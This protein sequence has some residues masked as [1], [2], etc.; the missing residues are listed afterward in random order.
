[1]HIY[2]DDQK[3]LNIRINIVMGVIS[4]LFIVLMGSF[5]WVQVLHAEKYRN[6]SAANALRSAPVTAKRGLIMDR[7]GKILADNQPSYSLVLS[8]TDLK[9][10]VK[11]DSQYEQK[12]VRF[13]AATLAITPAEVEARI[14]KGKNIPVNQ[15]LPLS[16]DL[17]MPQVAQIQANRLQFS[18]LDIAPVQRRNYRYGTMAAHVIGYMG[19]AAEKDL[20][21]DRS[22][23]PGDFV[24]KKGVEFVYDNLLRG[25]DGARYMVVDSHGRP[26]EELGSARKDPVAGHNVYLTLD[27][28]LQRL[29]EKYFIDNEFV[30][31]AV[32][33]DPKS[34]EVLAMVSSPAFNPNVFSKRFTPDMWAT[35]TSNPFH[36][37]Q[38][39]AIQGLYSPGSVFKTVMA[40]AGLENGVITPSTDFE[41][42]GSAVFY[43]RRFH[44]WRK[45]GHGEISVEDALKMSC[46]IFFYNTGSRLGVDRIADYAHN[47]TFGKVS[48]IDLE[49]ELPGLVPSEEWAEKVQ[50]RKWYP[51]ETISVSIGQGPLVVTVLQVANMMAAIAN[52]GNVYQP[53]VLKAVEELSGDGRKSL[54]V[55]EPKVISSVHLPQSALVAVR[56]GL[57]KVVN[58]EGGTAGNA[59]VAGL[60]I[61]GKTGTVQVTNETGTVSTASMPFKFR[62]HAWFA[63]FAPRD[64]PQMVVVVFIEHAG[65]HGGTD[66]APLAKMLY[67]SRFRTLLANGNLNLSDPDVLEQLKEGQLPKPGQETKA[68]AIP[69]PD[70]R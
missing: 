12:M 34:G 5:W 32:A 6:L 61:S 54:R 11:T 26:V 63:S 9:R 21:K 58:E 18:V 13:I 31:S 10:V 64:N 65:H 27:F 2:R 47:L 30:G 62:D 39:R 16:D 36:L 44:C 50:H 33:L 49:G 53:H 59:R 41:C 70:A 43:G 14:D 23:K 1:M 35:I 4:A 66:A 15:P 60:D 29:A 56:Q 67:E 68:P 28:D 48:G 55:V 57:W 45:Q 37:L 22:L 51:S 40:M 17:T 8:R 69:V 46:D 7:N 24:G 52:G 42:P 38:N 20:T 25:A 3:F 19:E